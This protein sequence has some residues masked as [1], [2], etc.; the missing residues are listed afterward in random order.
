MAPILH[1]SVPLEEYNQ[2]KDGCIK[3]ISMHKSKILRNYVDVEV[4][5][6]HL[7]SILNVARKVTKM[8]IENRRA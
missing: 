8:K 5:A 7:P 2:F 6:D 1:I 4:V 3:V